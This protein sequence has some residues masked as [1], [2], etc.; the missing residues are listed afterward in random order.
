MKDH[1]AI[2]KLNILY[3]DFSIILRSNGITIKYLNG[4]A[5]RLVQPGDSVI[6]I[7]YVQMD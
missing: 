3:E 4:V 6:I 1:L 2:K 7:A 5:A